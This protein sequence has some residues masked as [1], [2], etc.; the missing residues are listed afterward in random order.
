MTVTEKVRKQAS[1]GGRAVHSLLF[2]TP[3]P[4]PPPNTLIFKDFFDLSGRLPPSPE[5]A[6]NPPAVAA[7]EAASRKAAP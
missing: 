3:P 2:F 1:C 4:P 5:K 6:P 7:P